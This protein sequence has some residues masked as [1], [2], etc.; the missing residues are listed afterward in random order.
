MTV[1]LTNSKDEDGVKTRE[2][3]LVVAHGF[4]KRLSTRAAT[5]LFQTLENAIEKA[6]ADLSL[7]LT[8]WQRPDGKPL[9]PRRAIW[10]LGEGAEASRKFWRPLIEEAASNWEG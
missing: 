2:V 10:T 4:G 6:G 5:S 3:A 1:C 9:L 7:D 8:H